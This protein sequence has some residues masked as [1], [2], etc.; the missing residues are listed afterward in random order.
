MSK[1]MYVTDVVTGKKV[2][3]DDCIEIKDGVIG[4]VMQGTAFISKESANIAGY[5]GA[6]ER[7]SSKQAENAE[8][9]RW[10][11]EFECKFKAILAAIIV[12]SLLKKGSAWSRAEKDCSLTETETIKAAEFHLTGNNF[13][14]VDKNFET[15][16]RLAFLD[17]ECGTHFNL[18]FPD[19]A[20]DDYVRIAENAEWIFSDL[21]AHL[22]KNQ[23]ETIKRC[24]RYFPY[25]AANTGD[26]TE[27]RNWLNLAH[28]YEWDY[29]KR[30]FEW[31]MAKFTSIRQYVNLMQAVTAVF[32]A[33]KK[34]FLLGY[35]KRSKA[36]I[37]RNVLKAWESAWEKLD[38]VDEKYS[39]V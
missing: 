28:C 7:E 4:K 24:G 38:K 11:V 17:N 3:R 32:K 34:W 15:V 23:D 22:L 14:R 6:D 37:S 27:H 5:H 19:W 35:P 33:V 25:Y 39:R 18:S 26:Y 21:L 2:F 31:R 1:K 10:G 13:R 8:K 16:M 9:I 36:T 29:D 30:R 20:P 12:A